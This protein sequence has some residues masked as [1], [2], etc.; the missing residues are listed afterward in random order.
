MSLESIVHEAGMLATS[1]RAGDSEEALFRATRIASVA[2]ALGH[3]EVT[4]AAK[5]AARCLCLVAPGAARVDSCLNELALAMDRLAP[6]G[7]Y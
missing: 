7:L 3:D 5:Q 2:E 4:R 6:F 1:V